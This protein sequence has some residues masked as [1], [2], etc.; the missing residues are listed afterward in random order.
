MNSIEKL[1]RTLAAR[2]TTDCQNLWFELQ[3]F[4][5]FWG[6][7]RAGENLDKNGSAQGEEI[8][9][10]EAIWGKNIY[11]KKIFKNEKINHSPLF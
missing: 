11:W 8:W 7:E 3:D 4:V 10:K 2:N 5:F 9:E 6:G 1:D